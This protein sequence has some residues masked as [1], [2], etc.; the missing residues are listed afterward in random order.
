M[1]A[2]VRESQHHGGPQAAVAAAPGAGPG[3]RCRSP[4]LQALLLLKVLEVLNPDRKLMDTWTSCEDIRKSVKEP[5]KLLKKHSTGISLDPLNPKKASVSHPGQL[6]YKEKKS[7]LDVLH[8][9]D[10][11][12]YENVHREVNDF[13]NWVTSFGISNINEDFIMK[14]FQVDYLSQTNSDMLHIFNLNRI[15]LELKK[16]LGANTL[17]KPELIQKSPDKQKLQNS[18]NPCKPKRIKM[19]YGAWY[20]NTKLWKKLRADEPLVDPKTTHKAQDNFK[21]KF[22]KEELFEELH[23]PAAFKDFIL[24]KG[25]SMPSILEKVNIRKTYRKW[26]NTPIIRFSIEESQEDA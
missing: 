2:E 19:R 6:F 8:K 11:V 26:T 22:Q 24:R 16:S 14:Q 3:A 17:Q 13:C 23:G 25:Y 18:Q 5:E 1:P 21:K 20:L 15:P 10:P 9:D 12:F 4:Q 7:E